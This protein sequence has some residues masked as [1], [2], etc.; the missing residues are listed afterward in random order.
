MIL[1]IDDDVMRPKF[2]RDI[3]VGTRE[4]RRR[5]TLTQASASEY[6]TKRLQS[7]RTQFEVL[8]VVAPLRTSAGTLPSLRDQNQTLIPV[9][10]RSMAYLV[11][12]CVSMCF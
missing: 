2:R 7:S 10:L 6:D 11:F 9:F 5:C 3:T 1:T 12:L 8:I 4:E